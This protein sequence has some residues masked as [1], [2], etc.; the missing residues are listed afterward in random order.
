MSTLKRVHV[1]VHATISFGMEA[2]GLYGLI[3]GLVVASTAEGKGH[4][5]IREVKHASWL[6]RQAVHKPTKQMCCSQLI[7]RLNKF[8]LILILIAFCYY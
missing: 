3:V 6:C 4:G 8:N 5:E 1:H 2:L 7:C